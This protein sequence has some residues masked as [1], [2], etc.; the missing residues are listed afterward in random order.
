MATDSKPT[1]KHG[2][3]GKSN[4]DRGSVSMKKIGRYLFNL[5][6]VGDLYWNT[7]TGGSPEETVSAR[8]WDHYRDG[9]LRKTVDLVAL[10]I[11][12]EADHCQKASEKTPDSDKQGGVIP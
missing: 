4:R 2:C 6:Y 10:K 9:L 5:I 7:A 1:F 11:F 8:L 3:A 12:G